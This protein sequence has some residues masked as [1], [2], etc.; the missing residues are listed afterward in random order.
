MSKNS[1][2]R[3][4]LPYALKRYENG[5]GELVNRMYG[6]IARKGPEPEGNFRFE[7]FYYNDSNPPWKNRETY[8]RCKAVLNRWR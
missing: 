5:A 4:R 8:L 1:G 7:T 3:T 6:V 2:L